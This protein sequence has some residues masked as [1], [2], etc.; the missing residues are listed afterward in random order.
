MDKFLENK[1]SFAELVDKVFKRV[2]E[3]IAEDFHKENDIKDFVPVRGHRSKL[4]VYDDAIGVKDIS[5]ILNE[6]WIKS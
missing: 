5:E 4:A 2:E 3:R 1:Q 6:E